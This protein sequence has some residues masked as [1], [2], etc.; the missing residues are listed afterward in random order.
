MKKISIYIIEDDEEDLEQIKD[1]CSEIEK[2]LG[3]KIETKS[4]ISIKDFM[5][6][7]N[8]REPDLMIVDLRLEESMEDR[9]GWETVIKVLQREI[10][11]VIIYSAFSSEEP[12]EKFKNLIIRR[13]LKGEGEQFKNSLEKFIRLKIRYNDEKERIQNEFRALTLQTLGKILE[14]SDVEK[15][16][17]EILANLAVGR[18]ASYLMNTPPREE[19]QFPPETIYI[20][21][22]LEIKFYSKE[23]LFL[24]DFLEKKDN[25]ESG[26]IWLVISPSCDIVFDEERKAKIDEVLLLRC[27]RKYKEVLFLKDDS[28]ENKR[29]GE[30][31]RRLNKNTAKILKCPSQIFKSK[32]L[33]INF[34]DYRTV[35][36]AEIGKGIL[37]G[38]W[39]KLATLA[40][41]Y[42][43]SLQNLFIRDFSRIGTPETAH[44]SEEEKWAAEFVKNNS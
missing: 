32:Y 42:A 29:K 8:D 14:E 10:T 15:L 9:S 21:P 37:G 41:P 38:T 17:E 11:P 44:S 36:Y 20:F 31:K 35:S 26:S 43:E 6:K 27:N 40:T 24:G 18:L 25:G 33:L 7:I 28:N 22:P 19:K 2:G 3:I 13:V 30:L 16:D 23:C 34:K 5:K 12:E 39:K 4:F 1:Q